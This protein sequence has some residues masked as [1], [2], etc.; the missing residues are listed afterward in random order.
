[1]THNEDDALQRLHAVS[2]APINGLYQHQLGLGIVGGRLY[3]AELQGWRSAARIA[4]RILRGEPVSSFP[5]LIIG[6]QGPRYDWR[7]LQRWN[8]GEERLPAGSVVEFRRPTVWERYRWW[9]LGGLGVVL[10]EAGL[11]VLLAVNLVR[12][13]RVERALRD[14]EERVNLAVESAGVGLWTLDVRT[15]RLWA[16]PR[17]YELFQ[18]PGTAPLDVARFVEVI[19]PEDRPQVRR[20]F[21]SATTN[22]LGLE[23][24]IVRGDGSPR[25]IVTRGTS[26]T[27]PDHGGAEPR[28]TS[29]SASWPRTGSARASRASGP[30]RIPRR[31]SSGWRTSTGC[32]PSS[33]GPGWTSPVAR[34][35]QEMG[36]GWTE[37]VHPDDRG[38]CLEEWV[39]AFEARQPFVL[40]YRLRR[41]DGEYRWIS[42]N[43]V[44]RYDSQGIF[45]GYI[46]SC[47]DITERLRAEEQL[48][49]GVRG[50]A[51]RHDHGQ[52]DRAGS[53]SSTPRWRRSSGTGAGR[54]SACPSRR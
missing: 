21:E 17:L 19:H 29:P 45:A 27:A 12:R 46:G 42:D 53:Y 3:Q 5:P 15:G 54:S 25:W 41:H 50:G 10:L 23:F 2:S 52:R 24:R 33:T 14:S 28:W 36:N 4:I 51:Q 40:Q 18:L 11:I 34:V 30:S 20:A 35:E 37:S 13:W 9:I 16:T 31:F 26:T 32:A 1:M 7:E 39:A 47:L 38:S 8:I 48:P 44:P 43:G 49:A 6:A 22:E